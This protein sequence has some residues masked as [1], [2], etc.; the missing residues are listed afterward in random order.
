MIA[1]YNC[2]LHR[3]AAIACH[4]R[5]VHALAVE[6]RQ[7]R[8]KMPLGVWRGVT[9]GR[10]WHRRMSSIYAASHLQ[11]RVA[12]FRQLTPLTFLERAA[13]V[14]PD[15][16]AVRFEGESTSYHKLYS[17]A[18]QLASALR[19]RG[20]TR[21]DTVT[22][23]S[24]NSPECLT[25]HYGVPGAD[26]AVLHT[27]NTRLDAGTFA[28]EHPVNWPAT[29]GAAVPD[30]AAAW[31]V[32]PRLGRVLLMQPVDGYTVDAFA[33]DTVATQRDSPMAAGEPTTER[34]ERTLS[35][36]DTVPVHRIL[37][38]MSTFGIALAWRT[39]VFEVDG[40]VVLLNGPEE[41]WAT[42]S[43]GFDHIVGSIA[44][45]P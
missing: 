24:S 19:R 10:C 7:Q 9:A 27:V 22:V 1:G 29:E 8:P 28:F 21:G 32:E 36:G 30:A 4:P 37:S 11:R 31:L 13:L 34:V 20:V 12:N 6:A 23:F 41:D 2:V 15:R 40:V 17:N 39:E 42:L 16:V 33:A 38:E 25:A 35:D 3:R 26:G 14:W 18:K 45:R 43:P 44:A 5:A